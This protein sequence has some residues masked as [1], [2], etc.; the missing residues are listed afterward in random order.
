MT[1]K[2]LTKYI[3]QG[4]LNPHYYYIQL[5]SYSLHCPLSFCPIPPQ[6][7]TSK[8]YI[9]P[10]TGPFPIPTAATS[11]TTCSCSQNN[12]WSALLLLLNSLPLQRIQPGD[13]LC[14]FALPILLLQ[15][16]ESE[17]ERPCL[18]EGE[19]DC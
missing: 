12:I 2:M 4:F 19:K 13:L 3:K 17:T 10:C 16:E 18:K 5:V 9:A 15:E 1:R 11:A 6:P 7:H 8:S 14:T